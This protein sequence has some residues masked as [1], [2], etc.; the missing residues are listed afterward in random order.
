MQSRELHVYFSFLSTSR[1]AR[2]VLLNIWI[3]IT[4]IEGYSTGDFMYKFS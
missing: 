3:I 1:F 2:G 4:A